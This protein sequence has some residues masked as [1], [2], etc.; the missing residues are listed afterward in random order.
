MA[1]IVESNGNITM[2][3][4]DAPEIGIDGLPTDQNYIAFFAAQDEDRN[5]VGNEI[6]VETL[7]EPAVT[8]KLLGEL[9]D[10]FVVPE[11]K[12]SQ[13]YYYGVKICTIDGQT[14]D[15]LLLGDSNIGDLNVITV[16]P[17]K[18]KGV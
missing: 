1:Y 2:Y 9:T 17:R 13:K 6:S 4:G 10:L 15:T 16:Y 18:V 5:P 3:Q 7:G 12:K 8:F 14:E 11:D